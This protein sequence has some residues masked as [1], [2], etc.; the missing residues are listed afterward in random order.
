MEMADLWPYICA[1]L[2]LLLIW[3]YHQNQVLT[4]RIQAVDI[5]DRWGIR[6]YVFATPDD[7]EICESCREVN[8]M[9]YLP[10]RVAKRDFTPLKTPCTNKGR[11]LVLMI[12]L[13]GAW[14][15]ARQVVQKLR[16]GAKKEGMLQLTVEE[17]IGMT[18]G[19]WEGSVSA[20]TDRLSVVMLGA[21]NAEGTD[22]YASVFA[23]Q[24]IIQEAQEVRD[25]PLIVPAYL[26]LTGLLDR[27]GRTQEALEVI[28]DFEKR[29]PP[30][31]TGPYF[32][33]GMQRGLMTIKKSRLKTATNYVKASA[34][35]PS[36]TEAGDLTTQGLT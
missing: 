1:I 30:S 14:Q 5:F 13:Y 17:L 28:E 11:C 25:L 29:Y 7:E 8:G 21:L 34:P 18:K 12:G 20:A 27:Q 10:S 16:S 9:V 26:R 3:Q 36:P 6:M 24:Q 2:A 22:P 15:E 33:K 4:G 31:K 35:E 32:P 19:G 23:Y